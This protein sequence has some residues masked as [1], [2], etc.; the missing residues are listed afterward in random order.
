MWLDNTIT[1]IEL[2]FRHILP[3]GLDHICFIVAL[4]L[5]ASGMRSLLLQV[6][7]FTLAHS[8]TLGLAAANVLAVPA[9]LVEPVI[10]LSIAVV[11]LEALLVRQ[12]GAWRFPLIFGFGLF[13]GLGFASQMQGYLQGADFL[14][15][16]AGFNIGVELGQLVVLAIFGT[17]ALAVHSGLTRLGREALYAWVVTR[18]VALLIMLF[19]LWW[20]LERTGLVALLHPVGPPMS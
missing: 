6:T 3:L 1:F 18:P 20:F 7:A 9:G 8:V 17:G 11:G 19:G 14:T 16:L 15:A 2:G 13:H 12:A 5:T 10:A 4:F